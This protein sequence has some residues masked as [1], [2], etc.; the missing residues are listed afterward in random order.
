MIK[1]GNAQIPNFPVKFI[2]WLSWC[3]A[4]SRARQ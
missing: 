3:F 2:T 1:L 4:S